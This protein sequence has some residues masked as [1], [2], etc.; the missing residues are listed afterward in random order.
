MLVKALNVSLW[1]I[2]WQIYQKTKHTP[3]PKAIPLVSFYPKEM[4][5]LCPQTLIQN[6]NSFIHN[7][8]KLE[9]SCVN[10]HENG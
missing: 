1:K 6:V 4:K 2:I 7:S 10:Q 5:P 3:S 8:Q 9:T